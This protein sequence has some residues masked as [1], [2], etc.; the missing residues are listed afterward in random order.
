MSESLGAVG[1]CFG[2]ALRPR[3]SLCPVWLR[4]LRSWRLRSGV[5][6]APCLVSPPAMETPLPP[7]SYEDEHEHATTEKMKMDERR[8]LNH[9][10]GLLHTHRAARNSRGG[11]KTWMFEKLASWNLK[12]G[13]ED[14]TTSTPTGNGRMRGRMGDREWARMKWKFP[15]GVKDGAFFPRIF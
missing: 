11:K 2:S 13:M 12:V 9:N 15:M 8:A 3:V 1:G 6:R 4:R 14:T 5:L 10:T 7:V